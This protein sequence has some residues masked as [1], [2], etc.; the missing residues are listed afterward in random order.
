MSGKRDPDEVRSWSGFRFSEPVC[1]LALLAAC[2]HVGRDLGTFGLRPEVHGRLHADDLREHVEVI[3]ERGAYLPSQVALRDWLDARDELA[4][5][6]EAMPRAVA[7]GIAEEGCLAACDEGIVRARAFEPCVDVTGADIDEP[8]GEVWPDFVPDRPL[9]AVRY[10]I[11]D[12]FERALEGSLSRDDVTSAVDAVEALAR[13]DVLEAFEAASQGREL[14][15]AAAAD[16]DDTLLDALA[17]RETAGAL[18]ALA[19]DLALLTTI[20]RVDAALDDVR[21]QNALFAISAERW[22][23]ADPRAPSPDH[24]WGVRTFAEEN[25]PA[26]LR[27]LITVTAG[28]G[29]RPA[30]PPDNVIPIIPL[31]GV[32]AP[33]TPHLPTTESG[34]RKL[35]DVISLDEVRRR[36]GLR[37]EGARAP[38]EKEHLPAPRS[39]LAAS[40]PVRETKNYVWAPVEGTWCATLN[41]LS[42][43]DITWELRLMGAPSATRVILGDVERELVDR[44]ARFSYAELTAGLERAEFGLAALA[45]EINGEW[46]LALLPTTDGD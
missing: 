27:E 9:R 8:V 13:R 14:S 10:L 37:W 28:P 36:L 31:V 30:N 7:L 35:A 20:E 29:T 39:A 32:R 46:A 16:R 43:D 38:G 1:A 15:G 24:W 33:G 21:R 4:L 6:R 22:R 44:R 23:S 11:G 40:D 18:F 45:V 3:L 5:A 19:G 42:A 17:I 34:Q 41:R 2:T 25:A 12:V 26:L